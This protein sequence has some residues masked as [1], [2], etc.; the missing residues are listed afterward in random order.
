MS[1]EENE[2]TMIFTQDETQTMEWISDVRQTV[3]KKL[4]TPEDEGEEIALPGNKTEAELLARLLSDE[5]G[6]HMKKAKMR[7]SQ[8][9]KDSRDFENALLAKALSELAQGRSNNPPVI[10]DADIEDVISLPDSLDVE[11]LPGE[12]QQGQ[13]SLYEEVFGDDPEQDHSP[14][15]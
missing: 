8:N 2:E 11:P 14:L 7:L 5:E 13:V 12:T 6:Y 9:K 15:D 4:I 3:I 10:G 1:N